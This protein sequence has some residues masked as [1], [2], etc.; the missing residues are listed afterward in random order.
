MK[1][2]TFCGLEL[3]SPK[4]FNLVAGSGEFR[5]VDAILQL[6][7]NII[8]HLPHVCRKCKGN[9]KSYIQAKEK[10]HKIE[11]QL[12]ETYLSVVLWSA[13]IRMKNPSQRWNVK[14]SKLIFRLHLNPNRAGAILSRMFMSVGRLVIAVEGFHRILLK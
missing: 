8:N 6:P 12:R 2:C 3:T 10:F 1:S 5:P 14:R 11:E 4:D 7:F 9:L 13:P